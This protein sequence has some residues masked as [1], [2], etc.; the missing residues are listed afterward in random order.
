MNEQLSILLSAEKH[1]LSMVLGVYLKRPV[2]QFDLKHI[3]KKYNSENDYEYNIR[4][5]NELLC[6]IGLSQDIQ[7]I[8]TNIHPKIENDYR[9]KQLIN[10]L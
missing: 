10:K 7:I 3:S 1:I 6:T 2:Q 9:I 8:L 4:F 5:K